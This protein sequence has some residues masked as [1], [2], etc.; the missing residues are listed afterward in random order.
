MGIALVIPAIRLALKTGGSQMKSIMLACMGCAA[1]LLGFLSSSPAEAQFYRTYVS[2]G[3]SDTNTCALSSPCISIQHA[4]SRIINGGIVSCLDSNDYSSAVT[5]SNSVTIDCGGVAG[6]AS[7]GPFTI[8]GPGIEVVI[9]NITVFSHTSGSCIS[10]TNGATLRLDNVTMIGCGATAMQ[11]EP[12]AASSVVVSNSVMTN[13]SGGV[14][15]EPGSGGSVKATF[16]HVKITQNTGGGFKIETANGPVTA[17]II[18]SVISNNGGN[19]INV[20]G[21]GPG[22]PGIVSIKNSVIAGNGAAGVQAN[23]NNTGVLVQTTL[24]DQ[25]A[26]G[27]TTIVNGGTMITYGNNSIVGSNGSG[28]NQTAQLH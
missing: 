26:A 3:G 10:L 7:A 17:D 20:V 28:F 13:S 19:G 14:L 16:D 4:L 25:N 24:F 8:N 6:D 9:K 21:N 2:V 23:G 27:A 18:D 15:I 22:L 1:L 12:T 5:I 11:L